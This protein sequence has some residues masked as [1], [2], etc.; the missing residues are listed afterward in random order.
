[1]VAEEVPKVLVVELVVAENR[2]V[3]DAVAVAAVNVSVM[4]EELV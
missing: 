3:A 2:I 1:M 4:K